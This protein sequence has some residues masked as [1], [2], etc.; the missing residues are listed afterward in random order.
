MI[1]D[2]TGGWWQYS[3]I[4]EI[5]DD[6]RGVQATEWG[7]T[8]AKKV[9]KRL[10]KTE[11]ITGDRWICLMR[12]WTTSVEFRQRSGVVHLRKKV[13]KRNN[14]WRSL[15]MLNERSTICDIIKGVAVPKQ[16]IIRNTLAGEQLVPQVLI[17][18]YH[19][20]EIVLR[21][22]EVVKCVLLALLQRCLTE[23]PCE[24]PPYSQNIVKNF[25]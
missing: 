24:H 13:A 11:T 19:P 25:D 5:L 21:C 22:V 15:D 18:G 4:S 10:L 9:A 12:G 16:G 17:C 14:Y 6:I 2:T 3:D 8:S 1:C 23:L 20:K 7:G